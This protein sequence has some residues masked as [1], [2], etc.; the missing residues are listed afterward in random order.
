MP[1]SYRSS[2]PI[3]PVPRTNGA[4]LF[5]NLR[6]RLP[7]VQVS[8]TQGCS[9]WAS[10]NPDVGVPAILD[11]EGDD[12]DPVTAVVGLNDHRALPTVVPLAGIPANTGPK[13]AERSKRPESR[14][15]RPPVR[16]APISNHPGRP[17]TCWL[18]PDQ[19]TALLPRVGVTE[20]ESALARGPT[21][22]RGTAAT[23]T[24]VAIPTHTANLTSERRR[25]ALTA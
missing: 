9:R 19:P 6:G 20:P 24:E 14:A 13:A 8:R 23:P 25:S 1:D 4:A 17:G 12:F 18:H 10:A 22:R 11:L 3:D 7:T 15:F 5:S 2:M 16:P 21:R